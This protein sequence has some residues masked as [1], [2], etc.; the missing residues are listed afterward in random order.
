[1][2]FD[3]TQPAPP[4]SATIIGDPGIVYASENS[5]YMS[6]PHARTDGNP[7]YSGMGAE[8]EASVVH[9][10]AIGDSPS[11]TQYLASGVVKGHVLDQ[12]SLDEYQGH[13]R[14]ATSTSQPPDPNTHSTLSVLERQG[15]NLVLT[16]AVDHIAPSEDIRS[17]RFEEARGFV[18]TFKKTDPLF[19]FD[20]SNPVAPVL[21]GQVQIPGFST[22]IHMM[23][24]T[25]LLTIGYDA[26][27]QGSFAWFAGVRLQIFDVA[28]MNNPQLLHAEVIGT[29]GSSSEALANH[30]AFNYYAPKNIL[31][32]PMTI[33]EGGNLGSYGTDMTFSGLIVYDVT[34][35][36]GFHQRGEVAHPTEPTGNGYNSSLCSNW[37]A[38][39]SSEV[40]RSIV[41]DDFIYSVSD[42]R[43][44]AS[45]LSNL[46][47]DLADISLA[48]PGWVSPVAGY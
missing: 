44:K 11:A 1:M 37:W 48:N 15:A 43:V 38:N 3:L 45:S 30:L 2:S 4:Q 35:D 19:A 16:G 22:Y 13:L 9:Q 41:M 20:L 25:H 39:A 32:L 6:V 17:V 12:F 26:N 5:L 21:S 10:F 7:W 27:D 34:V 28:D 40:K 14:I 46:S 47:V 36:G 23:D 31:A 18:V 42:R 33:C 29:R 24:D 8:P